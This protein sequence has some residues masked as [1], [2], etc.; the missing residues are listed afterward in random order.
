MRSGVR[1]K[2]TSNKAATRTAMV[3]PMTMAHL[4]CPSSLKMGVQWLSP[5]VSIT[6]KTKRAVFHHLDLVVSNWL[7]GHSL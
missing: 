5:A 7:V 6:S 1:L 2:I 4:T 3:Y